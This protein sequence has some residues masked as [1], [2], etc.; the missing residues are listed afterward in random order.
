MIQSHSFFWETITLYTFRFKTLLYV[1]I[2]LELFCS[3]SALN[4]RSFS[5]IHNKGTLKTCI[6]IKYSFCSHLTIPQAVFY[7]KIHT[8]VCIYII[9]STCPKDQFWQLNWICVQCWQ[10]SVGSLCFT[11]FKLAINFL[12]ALKTLPETVLLWAFNN[13]RSKFY[14]RLLTTIY[15]VELVGTT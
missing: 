9:Y 6:K 1:F 11:H 15:F 3:D 5:K 8:V 12:A 14:V 7:P 10:V 13:L 2:H 4:E